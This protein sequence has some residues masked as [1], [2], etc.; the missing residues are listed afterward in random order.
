M[1]EALG[2]VV[3]VELPEVGADLQQKEGFGV[4]E[5]VKAASD[6]YA[7]VSGSVVE[8]NDALSDDPSMVRLPPPATREEP[9]E[10]WCGPSLWG[11]VTTPCDVHCHIA[12]EH[13]AVQGG[14]ADESQAKQSRGTR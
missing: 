12:G 10:L 11:A 14:L 5:S 1:Q 8:V 9:R 3:Y 4:V 7:P 6:V 13:G 2:D